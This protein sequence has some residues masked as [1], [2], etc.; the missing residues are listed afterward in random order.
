[1]QPEK[2]IEK[3]HKK[4]TALSFINNSEKRFKYI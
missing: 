4:N 1:M 2:K 3:K